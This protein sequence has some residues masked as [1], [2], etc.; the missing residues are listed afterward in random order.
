MTG[1]EVDDTQSAM[2]ESDRAIRDNQIPASSGPRCA[3]ASR[4]RHSSRR[5]RAV[6]RSGCLRSHTLGQ[7][8]ACHI[9]SAIGDDEVSSR[10][11]CPNMRVAGEAAENRHPRRS[12]GQG[13][14][15]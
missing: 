12:R 7:W 11:K 2:T 1:V 10:R 5:P 14:A 3:I 15:K 4:M 8:S 13:S 9:P 6:A